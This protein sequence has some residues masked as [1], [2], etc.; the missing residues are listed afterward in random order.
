MER[1][2]SALDSSVAK[3]ANSTLKMELVCGTVFRT[4]DE[5]GIA[6]AGQVW[7]CNHTRLHS[8]CGQVGPNR[9]EQYPTAPQELAAA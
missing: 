6:L 4:R 5:A 2:G 7:R 1:V 9:Y 3:S 8:H